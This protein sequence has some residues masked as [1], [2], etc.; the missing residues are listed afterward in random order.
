MALG[1]NDVLINFI[2]LSEER[3]RETYVCETNGFSMMNK[4]PTIA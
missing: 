3:R 2:F 4:S 1:V